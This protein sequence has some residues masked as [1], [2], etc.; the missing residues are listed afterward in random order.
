MSDKEIKI[1]VFEEVVRYL[2][3]TFSANKI[4]LF[5]GCIILI[6]YLKTNLNHMENK[7]IKEFINATLD[8]LDKL[9]T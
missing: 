9:G 1:E 3:N 7:E 5:D 6:S 2:T 8:D 4:N